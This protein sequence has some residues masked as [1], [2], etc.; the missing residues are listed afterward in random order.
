MGWRAWD[1]YEREAHE[2]WKALPWRERYSRQKL[3]LIALLLAFAACFAYAT[4]AR[5]ASLQPDDIHV[6]DGDT[7]RLFHKK[8]D[9]RLVGFNGPRRAAMCVPLKLS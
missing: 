8:S 9:V 6:I 3:W 2:R 5:G 4:I 1:A 7:I